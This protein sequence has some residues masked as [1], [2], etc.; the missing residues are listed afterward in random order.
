MY[1]FRRQMLFLFVM[2]YSINL[3]AAEQQLELLPDKIIY[4]NYI[5]DPLRSTNSIQYMKVNK[6]S[7]SNIGKN[8]LDIKLGGTFLFAEWKLRG[9]KR[10]WLQLALEAGFHGQFDQDRSQ[11]NIGWDGL[12]GINLFYHP[13]GNIVYRFGSKHISAHIGDELQERTGRTRISYTR[14]EIRAGLV[15]SP[16]NKVDN[17]IDVGRAYNVKD[18]RLQ[19]PWRAQIGIQFK[20]FSKF[21]NNSVGWFS[22]LDV[23]A[24]EENNWHRNLTFQIGLISGIHKPEWRLA[25]EIYD[26]RTQLGEF[27][28][29]EERYIGLGLWKDF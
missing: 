5:A 3:L 8:H 4:P 14:N 19:E 15:W 24:F 7:D 11:D 9:D 26:G 6:T 10:P 27:F 16:N 20:E 1:Q 21:F 25:V 13:A 18:K 22:A 17:Y 23:S 2:T 28:Q 29:D 12:Y